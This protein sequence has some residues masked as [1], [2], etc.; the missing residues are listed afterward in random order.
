MLN[1]I[2]WTDDCQGKKDYDGDLVQ[3]STRYWPGHHTVFDTV[4]P[5]KGLHE[6]PGGK[7][8]ANCMIYLLDDYDNPLA[9]ADFRGDTFAEVAAQV[10][11]WVET[12]FNTIKAAAMAAL[13]DV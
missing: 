13:S 2:E 8:H 1:G 7:P 5:E 11:A 6:V 9:K 12:Q 10:E 4:T 3:L